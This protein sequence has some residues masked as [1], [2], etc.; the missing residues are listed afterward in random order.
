MHL[1]GTDPQ[2]PVEHI[3]DQTVLNVL[4]MFG[5]ADAEAPPARGTPPDDDVGSGT[6]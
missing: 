1:C 6:P 2:A 3:A 5:M 4:R